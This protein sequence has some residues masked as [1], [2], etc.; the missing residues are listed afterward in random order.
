MIHTSK[1]FNRHPRNIPYKTHIYA[2]FS[3]AHGTFS[4]VDYILRQKVL[5]Y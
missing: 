2:F 4:N 5:K 1:V 3:A